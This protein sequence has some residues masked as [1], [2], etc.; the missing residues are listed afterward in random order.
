[1]F[2]HGGVEVGGMYNADPSARPG[3]LPYVRVEDAG[4]AA[5]AVKSAGGRIIKGPSEVPGGH[6]IAKVVDPVGAAFAVHEFPAAATAARTKSAQA[7]SAEA[8]EPATAT[9]KRAGS[10][11][12]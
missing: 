2:T 12:A 4:R 10:R 3:W 1:I 7:A 11:R 5:A 8:A 9:R 6:R